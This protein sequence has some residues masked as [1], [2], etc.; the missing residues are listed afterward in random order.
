[1]KN[2]KKGRYL[3]YEGEVYDLGGGGD[4]GEAMAKAEEALAAAQEAQG[5]ADGAAT[6]AGNAQDTA[7]AAQTAADSKAPIYHASENNTYGVG[8][9]L[10]YGHVKLA[11]TP[12]A[13]MQAGD[14]YAATPAAVQ[15]AIDQG[16]WTLLWTNA[17]PGSAFAAQTIAL[18]LSSYTLIL[19][20]ARRTTDAEYISAVGN[21]GAKAYMNYT[22]TSGSTIYSR[23][24]KFGI[25]ASGIAVEAGYTGTGVNNG[26]C[27]PVW[28]YGIK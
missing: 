7:D 15:A 27:I 24:R 11:D 5:T 28:I 21:I 1:M 26:Y 20:L 13:S 3:F 10:H 18:N 12:N 8:D 6:A 22:A 25:S 16:K 9:Y 19:I 23:T 14:G 4:S 2:I 17:S